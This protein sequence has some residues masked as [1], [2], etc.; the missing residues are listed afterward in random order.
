MIPI[1]SA[2]LEIEDDACIAE[3]IKFVFQRKKR[4]KNWYA[5]SKI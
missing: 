3:T 2:G 5:F 4:G 1:W